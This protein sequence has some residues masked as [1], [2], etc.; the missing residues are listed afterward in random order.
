MDQA[1]NEEELD[2]ILNDEDDFEDLLSE[3]VGNMASKTE[4]LNTV[5]CG[6][7]TVQIMVRDAIDESNFKRS[8]NLC[9]KVVKLLR[10]E[11]YRQD[12]RKVGIGYV[13]PLI[14]CTFTVL[15]DGMRICLW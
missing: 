14:Y 1:A 12:A 13:L 15:Q 7:H 4:L 8:L 11:K 3:L 10:T 6:A 5:R 9:R 2:R